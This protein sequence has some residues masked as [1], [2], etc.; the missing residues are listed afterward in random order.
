MISSMHYNNIINNT[1]AVVQFTGRKQNMD[2]LREDYFDSLNEIQ[3]YKFYF[4]AKCDEIVFVNDFRDHVIQPTFMHF[5]DIAEL[6][7]ENYFSNRETDSIKNNVEISM[8][9]IDKCYPKLTT[10]ILRLVGCFLLVKQNEAASGSSPTSVGAVLL[11]P[12]ETWQEID[13]VDA[14]LHESVHQAYI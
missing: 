1:L 9:L 2:T 3:K 4:N 8:R 11:N 5:L 6:N 12:S 14:I 10:C 7:H 13:Y